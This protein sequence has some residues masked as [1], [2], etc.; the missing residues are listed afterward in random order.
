[1]TNNTVEFVMTTEEERQ[2]KIGELKGFVDALN[3]MKKQI[4][5]SEKDNVSEETSQYLEKAKI[6]IEKR[7]KFLRYRF[8]ES[9]GEDDTYDMLVDIYPKMSDEKLELLLESIREKVERDESFG[10]V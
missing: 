5:L 7:V 4:R 9:Y 8:F 3:S 2:F 6:G 1:M 10:N